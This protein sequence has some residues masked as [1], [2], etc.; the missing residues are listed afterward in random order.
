QIKDKFHTIVKT[1][2]IPLHKGSG[3]Y[4]ELR[5]LYINTKNGQYIG[6]ATARLGCTQRTDRQY[7]RPDNQPVK[8]ISEARPPIKRFSCN[9]VITI[10]VDLC[11]QQA[12]ITV[13]H[14]AHERPT[15]RESN[16]PI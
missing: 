16:L 2:L 8:K 1:F 3:Y 15:Y 9:G 14:L 10:K 5:N 13:Y 4:W 7:K 12:I 11:E 6:C